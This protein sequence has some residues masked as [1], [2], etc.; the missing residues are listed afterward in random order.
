MTLAAEALLSA[1][2]ELPPKERAKLADALLASL[3]GPIDHEGIE[4]AW[5][6]EVARRVRV[7]AT[8]S[9]ALTPWEDEASSHR[10]CVSS[11]VAEQQPS[12]AHTGHAHAS[13]VC[14]AA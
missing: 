6:E 7:L 1:A 8:G 12:Q 14:Q 10:R 4:R 9:S 13:Q 2:L 5:R 3:D 11:R